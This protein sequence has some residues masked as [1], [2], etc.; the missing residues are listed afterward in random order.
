MP[1][2]NDTLQAKIQT[3]LLSIIAP[4]IIGCFTF[5]WN[6]NRTV[7][8]IQEKSV[9]RDLR[10][11]NVQQGINDLR[12]D[13]GDAKQEAKTT[14]DQVQKINETVIRIEEHQNTARR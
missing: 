14:R 10:I 8:V 13:L 9:Q 5:L 3:V 11:D 1:I 12:L 7:A 2:K 4:A 6:L